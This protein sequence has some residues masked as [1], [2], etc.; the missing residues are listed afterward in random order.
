MV[1]VGPRVKSDVA[2]ARPGIS[3]LV[4]QQTLTTTGDAL[5]DSVGGGTRVGSRIAGG[6]GF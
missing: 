5:V 4:V 2:L 6:T 3:V 1:A